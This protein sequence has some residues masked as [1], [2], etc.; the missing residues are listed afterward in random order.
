MKLAQ[1][2]KTVYETTSDKYAVHENDP[3]CNRADK[4]CQLF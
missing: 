2:N 3:L 1:I 4:K